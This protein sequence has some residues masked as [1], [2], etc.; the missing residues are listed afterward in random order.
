MD[1]SEE[2][3]YYVTVKNPYGGVMIAGSSV[4]QGY[5]QYDDAMEFARN[6]VGSYGA[7]NFT[8]WEAKPLTGYLREESRFYN[9]QEGTVE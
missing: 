7:V 5:A 2:R 9:I 3:R 8:I 6:Y 1:Y 4:P